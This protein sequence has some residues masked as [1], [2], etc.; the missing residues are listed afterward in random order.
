MRISAIRNELAEIF[1]ANDCEVIGCG[2]NSGYLLSVCVPNVKA[3]ILQNAV[4]D[5]GVVIGKGA[6]CSGS[7]RGNRVLSAMGLS[8]KQ[9]ENCVRISLFSDTSRDDAVSAAR[10]ILDCAEAIRS[11]HVG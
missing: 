5:K 10:I 4:H 6:A 8:Q 7:K 2:K 1:T 3:E 9:I 11:G